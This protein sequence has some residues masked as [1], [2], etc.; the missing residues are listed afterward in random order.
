MTRLSERKRAPFYDLFKLIVALI[1]M[2]ILIILLLRDRQGLPMQPLATLTR[3]AGTTTSTPLPPMTSTFEAQPITASATATPLPPVTS[4]PETQPVTASATVT[5][6]PP[7][8]FTPE[9]QPTATSV[10]A[11]PNPL[12]TSTPDVQPTSTESIPTS[13]ANACPSAPTR[14]QLGDK[15]RV[16]YRLNFRIHPGLGS[17]IILTNRVGTLMDVI[18]GPVCTLKNTTEGSK[19]YLWWNVRM[20]D[21]R[22]GWSAEAPLLLS[23]YFLEPV[24]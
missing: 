9:T 12:P 16:L 7:V 18:G 19:A 10:P 1:M 23:Y 22:E 11:T 4:T 8:T 2:I 5:P 6:L 3:S 21:D 15:V 13:D 17:P 24:H 14:I 20:E